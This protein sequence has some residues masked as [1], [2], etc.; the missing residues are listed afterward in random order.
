MTFLMTLTGYT[1]TAA[2]FP[3]RSLGQNTLKVTLNIV[4]DLLLIP[5]M[6]F[7]GSAYAQLISSYVEN[8]VSV[9]MLRR[10]DIRLRVTDYI[11]QTVLLWL[12][13]ALFWW[14]H[15]G[16]VIYKLAIIILFIVLNAV[17]ATISVEDL[18]LILPDVVIRRVKSLKEGLLHGR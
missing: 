1:L 9:W 17:L 2:G 15:T 11:K 16:G 18:K 6:G 8:P 5:I 13:A 4:G 10:S 7:I 14:V 12:C 3:W